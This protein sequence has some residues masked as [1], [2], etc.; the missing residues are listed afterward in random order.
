MQQLPRMHNYCLLLLI[1]FPLKVPEASSCDL[2]M[3]FTWAGSVVTRTLLFHSYYSCAGTVIGS[4]T[5]N[6]TTYSVCSHGNQHICFSP[7]PTH[8]P[9][10]L[11]S[12]ILGQSYRKH[13]LHPGGYIGSVGSKLIRSCLA[14]GLGLVYWAQSDHSSSC[15]P[16]DKVKNWESP[17]MKKN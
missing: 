6:H 10:S 12:K 13:R 8:W 9:T 2:C 16:S 17:Y 11:I 15:F 14:A 1:W 3:H 7:I 5:H 4:H